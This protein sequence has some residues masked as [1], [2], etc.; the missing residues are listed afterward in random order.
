MIILV[1]EKVPTMLTTEKKLCLACSKGIKGRIDKKF[2]DDYC[3]NQY[4]NHLKSEETNFMRNVMNAMRK[5][6]L[7]LQ[8]ILGE[9][10]I[11]KTHID[12]LLGRGFQFKY[13]T[14]IYDNKKGSLYYYCFEY[15][16]LPIDHEYFLVVK[17]K[18]DPV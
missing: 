4:N 11:T 5:N 7:I 16:Y 17:R 14:N 12:R 15:G 2:C 9:K 8:Q 13:H 18:T 10:R 6:R 3:R 1:V